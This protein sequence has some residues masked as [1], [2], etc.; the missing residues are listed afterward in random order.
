[1]IRYPA[2]MI[3]IN[4]TAT[5]RT[6]VASSSLVVY[7]QLMPSFISSP[8]PSLSLSASIFPVIL[9]EELKLKSGLME[10]A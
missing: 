4:I 3:M 7:A 2:K 10:P 5:I 9:K 6:V 1:M 8:K